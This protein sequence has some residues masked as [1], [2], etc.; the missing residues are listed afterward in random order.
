M[1][2]LGACLPKLSPEC[3]IYLVSEASCLPSLTLR[4]PSKGKSSAQWYWFSQSSRA[5]S[6][7][8][9]LTLCGLH[10]LCSVL[11]CTSES[12]TS[13]HGVGPQS[14]LV[15]FPLHEW[16]NATWHC[17]RKHTVQEGWRLLKSEMGK[18]QVSICKLCLLFV[19]VGED[20]PLTTVS[21]SPSP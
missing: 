19:V 11:C 9:I 12:R 2:T 15:E 1:K 21:L 7:V 4:I 10:T 18:F 14:I 20:L 6:L 17:F 16:V 13:W 3:T 8:G 5:A